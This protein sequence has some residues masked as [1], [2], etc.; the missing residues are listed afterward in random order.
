[1][2]QYHECLHDLLTSIGGEGRRQEQYQV[3]LFMDHC[4]IYACLECEH[5]WGVVVQE[6]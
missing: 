5:R 6:M 2:E 1:M 3:S 4:D